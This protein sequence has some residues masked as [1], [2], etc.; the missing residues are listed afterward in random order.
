MSTKN[1]YIAIN[2]ELW[3]N[4]VETHYN[5]DFY[6]VDEFV[7]GKSSLNS[8]ELELLGNIEGENVL[9]LQCHFGLDSLSLARLG[10]K[11]TAVDF[12]EE[13]IAKAQELNQK[14]GLDVEF[15]LSDIYGIHEVLDKEFDI[16]FASYGT[17]GW[18]PDIQKW[19]DIVSRFLKKGGSL[20]FAEFHPVVWTFSY[21]FK[22]V[23]YGYFNTG[24]IAEEIEGTYTDKNAAIRNKSI[25]WNH[26]LSDVIQALINSGLK[27][28][29]FQEFNYSPYPIFKENT[30]ISENR[31]A[32]KGL[33]DKLPLVY[34]L[35]AVK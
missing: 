10:A 29:T 9:H 5:S 17:I 22:T 31:F 24:E 4:K 25:S 19:A 2:K 7:K 3:N 21:D 30:E 6:N 27:I 32:V 18:L 35:K 20:V 28:E 1:D 23:E 11:V 15:I 26:T 13:A 14:L 34:A 33:E 16:V 12:S 8:I